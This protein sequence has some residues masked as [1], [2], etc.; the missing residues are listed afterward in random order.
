MSCKYTEYNTPHGNMVQYSTVH[1]RINKAT[2][3]VSAEVF[4]VVEKPLARSQYKNFFS[5]FQPEPKML[6]HIVPP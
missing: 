2:K 6:T 5:P 4:V 3:N 1:V